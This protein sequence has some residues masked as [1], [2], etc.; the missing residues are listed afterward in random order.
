[1]MN[2]SRTES[3]FGCSGQDVTMVASKAML[4]ILKVSLYNGVAHD[5]SLPCLGKI[6]CN[7]KCHHKSFNGVSFKKLVV[8]YYVCAESLTESLRF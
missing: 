3:V 8:S 1:M 2:M 5:W 6:L 7:C 4:D